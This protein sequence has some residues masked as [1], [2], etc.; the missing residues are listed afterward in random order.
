MLENNPWTSTAEF[1]AS[2]NFSLSTKID[3]TWIKHRLVRDGLTSSDSSTDEYEIVTNKADRKILHWLQLFDL[4]IDDCGN[5]EKVFLPNLFC[6]D[7]EMTVLF[8]FFIYCRNTEGIFDQIYFLV[9]SFSTGRREIQSQISDLILNESWKKF[10]SNHV[11]INP[12]NS[13]SSWVDRRLEEATY[14]KDSRRAVPL[15]SM[16][17]VNRM[18][19]PHIL[20]LTGGI[21]GIESTGHKIRPLIILREAFHSHFRCSRMTISGVDYVYVSSPFGYCAWIN[22]EHVSF[23]K[24]IAKT[25]KLPSF[26]HP[27]QFQAKANRMVNLKF[28]DANP[29]TWQPQITNAEPGTYTLNHG[30]ERQH[31]K[32]DGT[33]AVSFN[34]TTGELTIANVSE[35]EIGYCRKERPTSS[36]KSEY[37]KKEP[38]YKISAEISGLKQ[39]KDT[40]GAV[41]RNFERVLTKEQVL[42]RAFDDAN[43]KMKLT[44]ENLSKGEEIEFIPFSLNQSD[45]GPYTQSPT[46]HIPKKTVC[47][48]GH[49][50]VTG[51]DGNPK[52]MDWYYVK[53]KNSSTSG[54]VRKVDLSE[55]M[56]K[57]TNTLNHKDR[58]RLIDYNFSENIGPYTIANEGGVVSSGTECE[59]A[60]EKGAADKWKYV[61][62]EN[63]QLSGWIRSKDI[64]SNIESEIKCIGAF[65]YDSLASETYW[66]TATMKNN[67]LP[68]DVCSSHKTA[69][70]SQNNWLTN[71][72]KDSQVELLSQKNSD[73]T[74]SAVIIETIQGTDYV[75]VRLS[76]D[77]STTAYVKKSS[78]NMPDYNS[79]VPTQDI[80]VEGMINKVD[81][82]GTDGFDTMF[83]NGIHHSI[84][85]SYDRDTGEQK[86]FH[87]EALSAAQQQFCIG[88][89]GNHPVVGINTSSATWLEIPRNLELFS[90]LGL[91]VSH[92]SISCHGWPRGIGIG[93]HNGA[94]KGSCKYSGFNGIDKRDSLIAAPYSSYGLLDV[95]E[96]YYSLERCSTQDLR[97]ALYACNTAKKALY[98]GS[99]KGLAYSLFHNLKTA[100]RD[101][102]V[103]GHTTAASGTRNITKREINRVFN[104]E[105]VQIAS[106]LFQTELEAYSNS[107]LIDQD[108]NIHP[109]RFYEHIVDYSFHRLNLVTKGSITKKGEGYE[110]DDPNESSEVHLTTGG[111]GS[112]LKLKVKEVDDDGGILNVGIP[113]G[114]IGQSSTQGYIEGE[115]VT[116]NG[117]STEEEDAKFKIKKTRTSLYSDEYIQPRMSTQEGLPTIAHGTRPSE[118]NYLV[119]PGHQF[120]RTIS[121][122][123]WLSVAFVRAYLDSSVESANLDHKFSSAFTKEDCTIRNLN[124]ESTVSSTTNKIPETVVVKIPSD[125][126]VVVKGTFSI[127][128]GATGTIAKG[129]VFEFDEDSSKW[130]VLDEITVGT[131]VTS[132]EGC[133]KSK[134][135]HSTADDAG[136]N[137]SV[138]ATSSLVNSFTSN[139]EINTD[140]IRTFGGTKYVYVEYSDS[141]QGWVRHQDLLFIPNG[142]WRDE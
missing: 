37:E 5:Q 27:S 79:V 51:D 70:L 3:L 52:L 105:N 101:V 57:T 135:K 17:M 6:S 76:D 124:S 131:G 86:T 97:I 87:Q 118:S 136:K 130:E 81:F 91:V 107:A 45:T 65:E 12:D 121:F 15:S 14:V 73:E 77:Y 48:Y 36:G 80:V 106:S 33:S 134:S 78:V 110:V 23:T 39:I 109:K 133:L 85:A 7:E 13:V 1:T 112:N 8:W 49:N 95:S 9:S 126:P 102:S 92:I 128:S 24:S 74:Y 108:S 122:D 88:I 82:D 18:T 83:P 4:F 66:A 38:F 40:Q 46:D 117:N 120:S 2:N 30:I 31:T 72:F 64:E 19:E 10:G 34:S 125:V 142:I 116:I 137:W 61:E 53:H 96:L 26:R 47:N 84:S 32:Q 138:E 127:K 25:L 99:K 41:F 71:M 90:E 42:F 50:S 58:I 114:A 111:S 115:I 68:A 67:C 60:N 59:F 93:V 100:L 55:R 63:G 16:I 21:L 62:S 35:D 129:T 139:S 11:I 75:M 54:W 103:F 22:I 98:D 43:G 123:P 20:K 94:N 119:V 140:T 56:I 104:P 89:V 29:Y 132:I 113:Q 141:L 44:G 69:W 28:N